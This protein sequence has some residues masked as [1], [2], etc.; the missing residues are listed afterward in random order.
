M[1]EVIVMVERTKVVVLVIF[2]NGLCELGLLSAI[3][4]STINRLDQQS[5]ESQR[6]HNCLVRLHLVLAR[7][8]RVLLHL[9]MQHRHFSLVLQHKG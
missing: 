3:D 6:N 7:V 5:L 9:A 8:E 1:R 4:A 2:P